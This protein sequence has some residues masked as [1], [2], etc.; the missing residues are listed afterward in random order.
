MAEDALG[1]DDEAALRAINPLRQVVAATAGGTLTALFVTPFDVIKTRLQAQHGVQTAA[2][3]KGSRD[4]LVTIVRTEGPLALWRG[5]APALVLTVPTTALYFT[6]YERLSS[7]LAPFLLPAAVPGLS[8]LTARMVSVVVSCPLELLR[9]NLQS[10]AR[11]AHQQ[12]G[13][14]LLQAKVRAEG[15]KSLWTGLGP[16]I[17]RDVPFSVIYWTSYERIKEMI[18]KQR[19]HVKGRMRKHQD[20]FVIHFLSGLGAGLLAAAATT[21]FD[22]IKTRQQMHHTQH[23]PKSVMQ[24][25]RRVLAE[26]G[27]A[28]LFKGIVPRLAKVAPAC[29]IMISSYE[30]YKKLV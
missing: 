2:H 15:V 18:T 13:F 16:T 14:R 8:G 1:V 20:S 21:P 17:M 19:N 9:T 22:V 29:A 26:E 11:L 6:L 4:A 24:I 3:F 25:L 7:Q 27:A 30:L 28:G 5:L 10:H 12:N 23:Y